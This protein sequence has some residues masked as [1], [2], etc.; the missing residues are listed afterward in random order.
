MFRTPR[1]VGRISRGGGSFFTSPN[2]GSGGEGSGGAGLRGIKIELW[3]L[4]KAIFSLLHEI[5]LNREA[6]FFLIKNWLVFSSHG[7]IFHF[8]LT[9]FSANF[10][11]FCFVCHEYTFSRC[12]HFSFQA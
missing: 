5:F 10:I 2:W 3:R 9:F 1:N 6:F 11:F 12:V 8:L 7:M 4:Q